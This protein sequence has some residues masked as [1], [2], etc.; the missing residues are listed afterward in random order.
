MDLA[1]I[2][3]CRNQLRH[4]LVASGDLSKWLQS[5]HNEVSPEPRDIYD[6]TKDSIELATLTNKMFTTANKAHTILHIL[7]QFS[8]E[9]NHTTRAQLVRAALKH[10]HW[11]LH[12]YDELYLDSPFADANADEWLK[13]IETR[14]NRLVYRIRCLKEDI[15]APTQWVGLLKSC[16]R[17]SRSIQIVYFYIRSHVD[18][19][20]STRENALLAYGEICAALVDFEPDEPKN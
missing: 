13:A 4:V 5:L 17:A 1:L 18:L 11:I 8:E 9:P 19:E 16:L 6:M 3:A 12:Q 15:Q 14:I 10:A 7:D 2:P 20:E